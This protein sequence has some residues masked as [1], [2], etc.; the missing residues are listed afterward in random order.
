MQAMAC[1]L[2]VVTT[3]VG[4]IAE[5]VTDGVTGV[6]ARPQDAEALRGAIAALLDDGDRRRALGDAAAARAVQRF[7]ESLM[8]ERMLAAFRA[9]AEG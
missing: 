7:G 2:P 9:A 6:M 1:A 4:S 3:D 8:V 5:I